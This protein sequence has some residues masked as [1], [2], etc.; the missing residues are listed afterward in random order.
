MKIEIPRL[1]T[2]RRF[3][4][5]SHSC[6]KVISNLSQTCLKVVSNLSQSCLKVVSK[7]SKSFLFWM[8][9][10]QNVLTTI[11]LAVLIIIKD[12]K[13]RPIVILQMPAGWRLNPIQPSQLDETIHFLFIGLHNKHYYRESQKR[14]IEWC[15]SYGAQGQSQVHYRLRCSFGDSEM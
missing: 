1:P 13:T 14:L 15:W 11:A 12:N 4:T 2:G 3:T 9:A 5:L 10:P 7:L 8:D 6:L